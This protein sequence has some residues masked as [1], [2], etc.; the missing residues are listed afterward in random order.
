MNALIQAEENSKMPLEIKVRAH[1]CSSS[2]KLITGP[3]HKEEEK[4]LLYSL[5][6]LV[7]HCTYQERDCKCYNSHLWLSLLY[8]KAELF[9]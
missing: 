7:I 1:H 8:H 3:K 9:S 4:M 5:R 6:Q 2:S